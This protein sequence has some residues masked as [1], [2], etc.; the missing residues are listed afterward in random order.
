MCA[1]FNPQHQRLT[2]THTPKRIKNIY[3][4]YKKSNNV[5]VLKKATHSFPSKLMNNPWPNDFYLKEAAGL[6]DPVREI[7]Y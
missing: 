6:W 4:P 5:N 2:Q 3:S 1:G 7:Q